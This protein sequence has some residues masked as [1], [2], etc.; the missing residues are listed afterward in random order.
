MNKRIIKKLQ[1][2]V[3]GEGEKVKITSIN[4]FM[5]WAKDADWDLPSALRII[6]MTGVLGDIDDD[7]LDPDNWST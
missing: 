4:S 7:N 5:T 1:K 3:E 6:A 2:V